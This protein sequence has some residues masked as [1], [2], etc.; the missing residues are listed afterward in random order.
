MVCL[1]VAITDNFV[2]YWFIAF[3]SSGIN[4][5]GTFLNNMNLFKHISRIQLIGLVLIFLILSI[6]S[7]LPTKWNETIDDTITDVQ[8][9]IRGERSLSPEII[10]ISISAEDIEALGGNRI[11]RDYYG[12]LLHLLSSLGPAVIGMDLLFDSPDERYPEYD[13]L[14]IDYIRHS[15]NICLPYIF[16]ELAV[17]KDGIL[18]GLDP[19]YPEDRFKNAAKVLGFSN[20]GRDLIVRQVPIICTNEDG[21]HF[22]FGAALA[23]LY[24]D[25]SDSV[26]IEPPFLKFLDSSEQSYLVKIDNEGKIRLNPIG[27]FEKWN[28]ISM[29]DFL[30]RQGKNESLQDFRNKLVVLAVTAPGM[31]SLVSTPMGNLIPASLIHATVVENLINQNYIQPI[32][33]ITSILIMLFLLIGCFVLVSYLRQPLVFIILFIILSGYWLIV[34]YVFNSQYLLVPIFIIHLL[35]Y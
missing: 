10:V 25:L 9:G 35:S 31:A 18:T 26:K 4:E 1:D 33:P 7:I 5:L 21:Y 16:S 27:S 19:Y 34:Q 17:S 13:D 20:L 24:L 15:G 22:S 32:H 8:F 3:N 29:V 23:R 30:K 28:A 12:Y 14:L 2:Y 11:T 6:L